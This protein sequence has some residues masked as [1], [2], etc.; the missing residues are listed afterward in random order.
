MPALPPI[1]TMS[2]V[3]GRPSPASSQVRRDH[4]VERRQRGR[5]LQLAGLLA[6]LALDFVLNNY[7]ESGEC[8]LWAWLQGL[9]FWAPQPG[10]CQSL[11]RPS[12]P[13]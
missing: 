8:L 1:F 13:R 7:T 11:R 5:L 6:G 10:R 12:V 4:S 9:R 2:L 3:L